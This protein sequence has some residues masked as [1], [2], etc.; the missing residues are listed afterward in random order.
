MKSEKT[1]ILIENA[2]SDLEKIVQFNYLYKF[3][4]DMPEFLKKTPY[5]DFLSGSRGVIVS[6]MTLGI[7]VDRA[8]HRL[9]KTDMSKAVIMDSCANAYLEFLSDS[10]EKTLGNDL[11]YRFCPGY[12]GSSVEDLKYIFELLKPE[13][14]GMSLGKNCFMLPSKSMAGVIAVGKTAKKSCEGCFMAGSCGYLKEGRTCYS[15]AKK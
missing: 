2:M 12:G 15:P 10:Y 4:D 14:I 1:D 5:L 3:F 11:S 7:E 6:A 13:K 9:F 8:L